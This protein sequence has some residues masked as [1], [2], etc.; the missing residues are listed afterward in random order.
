MGDLSTAM[1][2]QK[3]ETYL[4]KEMKDFVVNTG[5]T[6][7]IQIA[8]S[9][10]HEKAGRTMRIAKIVCTALTSAGLASLM[11]KL[12]PE[13]QSISL[14]VVFSLSLTTTITELVEKDRD[15]TKLAERTRN[16]A[17]N[18]WE[19]RVDCESLINSLRSGGDIEQIKEEF[20][21]LRERRKTFNKDIP[22]PSPKAVSIA[23]QRLKTNKDNNYEEDY[24]L[25]NL[26]D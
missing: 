16:V 5:W 25:F 20:S 7:K 10:L 24:I 11:L 21:E 19:L 8:Q 1:Q 26:E 13:Y 4:L 17:N 3:E 22:N 14:V 15:F 2:K 9:D 12:L 23:S 18:F 6:H